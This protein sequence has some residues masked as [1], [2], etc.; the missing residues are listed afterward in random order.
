M[1]NKVRPMCKGGG[2]KK[3]IIGVQQEMIYNQL[4]WVV[5]YPLP[6]YSNECIDI[7]YIQA[8]KYKILFLKA[9]FEEIE[10]FKIVISLNHI[11]QP[12]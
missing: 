9:Q 8:R 6:N 4:Q 11:F 2:G 12:F 5:K 10:L 7:T 1:L 3:I